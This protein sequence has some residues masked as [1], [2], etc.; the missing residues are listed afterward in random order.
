MWCCDTM[1]DVV[2]WG[3]WARALSSALVGPPLHVRGGVVQHHTD[4]EVWGV[5]VHGRSSWPW[6]HDHVHVGHLSRLPLKWP[7]C[8]P[9]WWPPSL[10]CMV[11]GG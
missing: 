9:K 2:V 3:T 5:S 4:L 11:K 1:S 6:E 10:V 8:K 7:W